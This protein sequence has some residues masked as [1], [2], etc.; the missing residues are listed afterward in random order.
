MARLSAIAMFD[1]RGM[2]DDTAAGESLVSGRVRD[3]AGEPDDA[4]LIVRVGRGDRSAARLLMLRNLPRVLGLARRML[5]DEMEAEDIAQETFIRVWK[6]APRWQAG[7]AQV[8]TWMCRIAINL[9][10]D[11]LRRRRE[12]LTDTPPEQIDG[13]PDAETAMTRAQSGD[14]IAAAMA[15][16]PDRQRQALELVHFQEMSNIDA[17][18]IMSVSV[19]AMESLLARGRR[20]LK[21]ILTGDAPDLM[22]SYTGQR[23][24]RY[25]ATQ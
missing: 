7:S 15:Q 16:L 2:G 17:A 25:G 11:R 1:G 19:E 21:A 4:D 6:A 18:D 10:Y 3:P 5:N 9:C 8:S 24:A 20:K 14:R 23:D 22:A 13:A 12:V